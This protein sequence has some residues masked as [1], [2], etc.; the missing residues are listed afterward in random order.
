MKQNTA[1]INPISHLAAALLLVVF[2]LTA[3]VAATPATPTGTKVNPTPS[4]TPKP[5][6]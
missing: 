3:A 2:N 5:S 4:A 1:R 6:N